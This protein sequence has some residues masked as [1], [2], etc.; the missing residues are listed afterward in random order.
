MIIDV[1]ASSVNQQSKTQ[2][3]V[4]TGTKA[5]TKNWLQQIDYQVVH[6]TTGRFRIRVPRLA[7]D[8]EYASKLTWLVESL[9]FVIT[10]R[11]NPVAQ[12]VIVNYNASLIIGAEVQQH[13][14]TAIQ[15]ASLANIPVG[16]VPSKP[17]SGSDINW[18]RLG[19]S[20]SSLILA[21]LAHQLGLP[22][23]SLLI[24]GA[25]AAAATHFFLHV[26]DTVFNEHKFDTEILDAFWIGFH[27]IKGDF[28]TPALMLSLI[29]SG[30]ALRNT[31]AQAARQ[32]A[33]E[34]LNDVDQYTWVERDGKERRLP[35]IE[36]YPGDRIIVYPGELIPIT[37]LVIGGTA[38]IDEHKLTGSSILV[39]RTEGQMVHAFT[40]VIEGRLYVLVEQIGRQ[41]HTPAA[42]ELLEAAPIHDTRIENHAAKV[43]NAVVIPSFCLSAAIFALTGDLIRALAPLQLDCCNG[44]GITVPTTILA[45]LTMLARNGVY[46]RSGRALEVLARTNTVVFDK[47]GTLTQG[48][49]VVVAILTADVMTQPSEVLSL[50]AAA[51]QEN[52]HPVAYAIV[53][54][55]EENGIKIPKCETCDY[56]IGMGITA[57][58]DEQE[59]LVGSHGLMQQAGIDTELI[60]K[61]Y[62]NLNIDTRS[63]IYVAR[64]SE[65]L[66]AIL[67][68]DSV[69]PEIKGAIATL[70]AKDIDTYMLTGDGERV[71]NDVACQI[72]I[73]SNNIYAEVLPDEKI[74]VIC[75]M[76][77]HGKIVTFVGEGLNDAA[78]LAHADVSVSLKSGCA[79][80]R[81][82]ADVVLLDNDLRGLTHA[83]DIAQ[84]T[85][86]IVYLNTA[87]AVIPNISVVIA[88]IIFALDPLL[89]V[90][91]SNVSVMIAELNSFRPLFFEKA[92][93]NS[94]LE[95]RD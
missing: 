18:G 83:I 89:E 42:W 32:Q 13:L 91:V 21:L 70:G 9:D 57:K 4:T 67:Y 28:V 60:Y 22:I 80:A 5:S 45:A 54:C 36:L 37:G 86:E 11:I 81:E 3:T 26:W 93:G 73:N 41:P 43:A 69:R 49:A 7:N 92:E 74:E 75:R 59:I 38:L 12:S 79:L 64:D 23:P 25:V 33:L 76:R 14:F 90:I 8:I 62:P 10:V 84:Q 95:I 55:A 44:I 82:T 71:A 35:L 72:G 65:L 58:I 17:E 31:T 39:S 50:A 66:G 63:C 19:L 27:T 1:R 94:P 87:I 53:R 40:S 85:M 24:A 56:Q 51:E 6:F 52:T 78:A 48:F 61:R 34:L 77:N 47:T 88:G 29:E 15:R 16:V 46:I 30:N 20:V 2:K 68:T